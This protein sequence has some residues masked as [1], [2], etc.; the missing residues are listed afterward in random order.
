MDGDSPLSLEGLG[1]G[2]WRTVTEREAA[3]LRRLREGGG[4]SRVSRARL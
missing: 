3:R 2:E 1:L 4:T